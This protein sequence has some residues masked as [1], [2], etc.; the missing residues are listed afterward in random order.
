MSGPRGC[1]FAEDSKN[2]DMFIYVFSL[3]VKNFKKLRHLAAR[4]WDASWCEPADVGNSG[5]NVKQRWSSITTMMGK[6]IQLR[7]GPHLDVLLRRDF[8]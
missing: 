6:A 4:S 7:A 1:F 3:H 5:E 8:S 2:W